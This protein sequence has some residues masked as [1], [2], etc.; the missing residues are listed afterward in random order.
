MTPL[1]CSRDIQL[2]SSAAHITLSLSLNS[3]FLPL[4]IYTNF[5]PPAQLVVLP[6]R[7]SRNGRLLFVVCWMLCGGM[8]RLPVF[9]LWHT[10]SRTAR[11]DHVVDYGVWR[12][13]ASGSGV[14][15]CGVD[16]TG[17]WY[18]TV[19]AAREKLPH[20]GTTVLPAMLSY[21][22]MHNGCIFL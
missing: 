19:K 8:S 21:S 7:V 18:G 4:P 13:F 17:I 2:P 14:S 20:E 15:V 5:L 22:F 12:G 1:R 3:N 16:A 10:A 11:L 9:A 6:P